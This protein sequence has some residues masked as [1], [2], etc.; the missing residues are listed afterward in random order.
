MRKA[1][2][3]RS[4]VTKD[5]S[6]GYVKHEELKEYLE[7][8]GET[9]PKPIIKE[10]KITKDVRGYQ[11]LVRIPAKVSDAMQ[12]TKN[13]KIIFHVTFPDLKSKEKTQ[14]KIELK[15]G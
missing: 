2:A 4:G 1:Y 7:K 12:I 13:D 14:L 10:A 8:R 9:Q 3:K 15:R 6:V 5:I 11:Y